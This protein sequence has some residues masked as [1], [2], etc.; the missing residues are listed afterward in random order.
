MR[1]KPRDPAPQPF[2]SE[3][4]MADFNVIGAAI[5]QFTHATKGRFLSAYVENH[6][7]ETAS[8]IGKDIAVHAEGDSYLPL[9]GTFTFGEAA[10]QLFDSGKGHFAICEGEPTHLIIFYPI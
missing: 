9:Y 2:T 1:Q 3:L 7:S 5:C 8:R 10:K 6:R 4:L